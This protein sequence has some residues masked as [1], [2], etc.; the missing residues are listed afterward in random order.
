[1]A[2]HVAKAVRSQEA[3]DSLSDV[4][5]RLAER[6][7]IEMPPAS[8]GRVADPDLVPILQMERFRDT[9][10]AIEASLNTQAKSAPKAPARNGK[11][12]D[13]R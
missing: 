2:G 1:M 4:L 6:L 9:L 3:R 10:L 8:T 12:N 11:P 7:E 13:A 5:N